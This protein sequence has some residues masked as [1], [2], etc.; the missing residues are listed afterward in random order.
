[1]FTPTYKALV[2]AA[3]FTLAF[4]CGITAGF[5]H[6]V[7]FG[8]LM[9]MHPWSRETTANATVAAGFMSITNNGAED[10]RLVAATAVISD[11]VQLH[12]MTMNG[13]VMEMQELK[14]GIVI[15]AGKTVELKPKS[16]HIMFL[17]IKSHPKLGDEFKGTLT[18]EKAGTVDVD[19]EIEAADAG[20]E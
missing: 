18:F 20:M 8:N 1:M 7:T 17:N 4:S 11:K 13:D 15:P 12:N 14:D 2:F 16:L 10:D 3:T 6:H 5:A 19:F 9:I